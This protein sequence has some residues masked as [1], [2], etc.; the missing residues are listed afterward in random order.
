MLTDPKILILD[1]ATSALDTDAEQII[2]K[3]LDSLMVGRTTVMI[4]HRLS[5]V[6]NADTIAFMQQG[7][8]VESGTHDVLMAKEEPG[9]YATMVNM[10]AARSPSNDA[11]SSV[12]PRYYLHLH[13]RFKRPSKPKVFQNLLQRSNIHVPFE[14]TRQG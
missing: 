3:A 10:Q 8:I 9:A 6:R 5:T 2:C 13:T 7:Q 4:A 1:E 12:H 14:H 11:A